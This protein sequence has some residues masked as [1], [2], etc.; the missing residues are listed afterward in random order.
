MSYVI[1]S[2]ESYMKFMQN[3]SPAKVDTVLKATIFSTSEDANKRIG[4][5]PKKMREDL[6]VCKLEEPHV[7]QTANY[8]PFT[9]GETKEWLTKIECVLRNIQSSKHSL[10]KEVRDIELEILDIEH[11]GELY[12]V[13]GSEGYN[14]FRRISN[15]RRERREIKDKLLVI[16]NLANASINQLVSGDIRRSMNGLERREYKPRIAKDLF[17]RK[18]KKCLTC[19]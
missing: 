5:I 2:G 15:L 14:L 7:V 10:E 19:T 13:S 3:S 1:K 18:R 12:N 11:F 16:D 9:L 6:T 4:D 8:L 17:E